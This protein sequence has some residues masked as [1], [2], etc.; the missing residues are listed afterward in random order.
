MNDL[1]RMIYHAN[2]QHELHGVMV[3]Y[4]IVE[5]H[6]ELA[7]RLADGWAMT[8]LEAV[9][10]LVYPET[11]YVPVVIPADDA[12]PTRAELELKARE[13]AIPFDGRTTDAKL[14]ARINSMM[15]A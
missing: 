7:A 4:M 5:T 13:L 11:N 9:P 8:P 1:P 14:A 6:E 12:P 15:G 10:V 2:G 3:D